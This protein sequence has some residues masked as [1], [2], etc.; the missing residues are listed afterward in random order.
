[1][2]EIDGGGSSTSTSTGTGRSFHKASSTHKEEGME[3]KER[4]VDC[5]LSPVYPTKHSNWPI[6]GTLSTMTV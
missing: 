3:A 5:V 4:L 1:M 2:A 6:L